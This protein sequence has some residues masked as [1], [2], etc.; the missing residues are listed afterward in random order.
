MMTSRRLPKARF[1]T[2]TS[3]PTS[4]AAM[5]VPAPTL[6]RLWR[7]VRQVMTETRTMVQSKPIFTL[8]NSMPVTEETACMAPS[9]ARGMRSAGR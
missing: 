8:G 4:T 1:S 9:P 2:P 5:T 3:V 7:Q 6:P